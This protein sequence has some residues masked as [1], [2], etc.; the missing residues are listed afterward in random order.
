MRLARKLGWSFVVSWIR[1]L[2]AMDE[3]RVDLGLGIK[4]HSVL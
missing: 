3:R 1:V 2:S 4:A